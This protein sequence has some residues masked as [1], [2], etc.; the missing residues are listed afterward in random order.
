MIKKIEGK[1]YIVWKRKR[2]RGL[3]RKGISETFWLNWGPFSTPIP[4]AKNVQQCTVSYRFLCSWRST[5]CVDYTKKTLLSTS[6]SLAYMTF[7]FFFFF[8]WNYVRYITFGTI[9]CH[10][11]PHSE[12]WLVRMCLHMIHWH[13]LTKHNSSCD[14]KLR[15]KL[16]P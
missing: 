11:S 14:T 10:N 16:C 8:F 4:K 6:I 2:F 3:K 13:I 9:L 1:H 7:P 12:L 15:Q 5:C